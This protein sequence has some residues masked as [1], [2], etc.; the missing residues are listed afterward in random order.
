MHMEHRKH[1]AAQELNEYILDG[2]TRAKA[3]VVALKRMGCHVFS[4]SVGG[5]N[6][7]VLIE[8]P[9]HAVSELKGDSRMQWIGAGGARM[10]TY[11]ALFMNCRVEWTQ[12]GGA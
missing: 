10:V 1:V 2:C 6:P 3:A 9:G 8:P 5:K 11:Q 4:V 12:A 7:K